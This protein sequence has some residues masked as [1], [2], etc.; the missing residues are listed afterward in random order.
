MVKNNF[1]SQKKGFKK[2]TSKRNFFEKLTYRNAGVKGSEEFGLENVVK[3]V[4]ETFSFRLDVGAPILD[5]GYFAN[6]LDLGNNL[7]LAISTDSVGTKVIVAQALGKFDTIG[8]DCVAMNA[9]DVLCVGAE[10]IALV[11]YIAVEKAD[12]SFIQE[13]VAGLCKGARIAGVSIPGGEVAQVRE[14]LKGYSPG[15]GFD[16]VGTC[17]GVVDLD[18]I[19]IGESVSQGDVVV[20]FSSSGVHSNGL[21]LAR[22]ALL[23]KG[24]L[25]FH[26]FIDELGRTLGEELL[27]PTRIYAP[28]VLKILKRD[29]KVKAL[30]HI[31]GDGFLNLTRV[32]KR[33]SYKI[34]FLPE[35]PPIFELIQ[36]LGN[37]SDEEMFRVFNMGVGFC[38]IVEEEDV[39]E[40]VRI[41]QGGG[42][43]AYILGKVFESGEDKIEL[44]PKKLVGIKG[45]FFKVS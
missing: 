33:V 28:L 3:A 29:L 15:T 37:I 7:G 19:I 18:K 35:P 39:D 10:P 43:K 13:I 25:K 45:D 17:V 30:I 11:D 26:S 14:I 22:K 34:D 20:G 41:S 44:M 12:P 36:K 2:F 27:E 42:V 16:L 5:V 8:I 6:V 31:T 40:V 4:K 38:V 23:D 21:T 24:G 1:D 9:N 32:K